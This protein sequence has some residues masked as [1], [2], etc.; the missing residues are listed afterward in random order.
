[1]KKKKKKAAATLA[2]LERV[3]YLV[4]RNPFLHHY[5]HHTRQYVNSK[6][7]R[8]L[9]WSTAVPQRLQA[10]HIVNAHQIVDERMLA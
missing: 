5:H 2:L 7:T 6:R 10:W 3:P 4:N 9:F 8:S 1:M